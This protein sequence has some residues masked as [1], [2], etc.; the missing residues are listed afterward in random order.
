MSVHDYGR[1]QLVVDIEAALANAF[2][3]DEVLTPAKLAPLDQFH[4]RGL[5]AT[6]DLAA[7]AGVTADMRILDIG[8]G[9]GGPARFLAATFGA[10]VT[11]VDVTP[12]YVAAARMLTDRSRL[13]ESVTFRTADALALP[14]EDETFDLVW[15]QH[16]AMNVGDRAR[17]YAEVRRV[18]RAGGRFVT[19]DVVRGS[20]PVDYPVPWSREARTSYLLTE[21]ET[22][23][24]LDD[25]G[26]GALVWSIDTALANA[27][28]DETAV[29]APT[30]PINLGLAVGPD[31]R[32]AVGN[33]RK[34]LKSGAIEILS[35]VLER[36]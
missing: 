35:A 24:A 36:R 10:T 22:R 18:L 20:G 25:A 14:F 5:A 4:T 17:L 11:G 30:G 6:A 32:V 27:W 23:S 9:L 15:M 33:L 7:R 12:S 31:F 8:S 26:F 19:Y 28:F 1:E 13:A 2:A 34:N 3:D 16:V 29:V 21:S